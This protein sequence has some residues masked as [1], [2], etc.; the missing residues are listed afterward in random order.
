MSTKLLAGWETVIQESEAIK[1]A[2]PAPTHALP[3]D[4]PSAANCVHYIQDTQTANQVVSDLKSARIRAIGVDSEYGFNTPGISLRSKKKLWFDIRSQSPIVVSLAVWIG[5]ARDSSAGHIVQYVFDVRRKD[6][7]HALAEILRLR[8]PFVFHNIK[9]ELFTF[10]ALGIEPD[11][12]D[13]YD[14]Y[15]AAASLVLGVHH[16]RGQASQTPD[17]EAGEIE[18]KETADAKREH[19]LSLT[20][21]CRQYSHPHPFEK[22]KSRLQTEFLRLGPGDPLSEEQ[23]AYAAA[24]ATFTVKVFVAQQ[25]DVIRLAI[26][27]HLQTIELPFAIAN[28][29]IEWNG[30]HVALEAMEKLRVG[31]LKAAD[32]YGHRLMEAGMTN[33][34]SSKQF[35]NLMAKHDLLKHFTV[36]T[37]GGEPATKKSVLET[38]EHLHPTVAAYR[39]HQK[40]SRL[41]GEEWLSGKMVGVDGRIHSQ[42]RQLGAHSGRNSCKQPNLA[43]IGKNFRPIVSA[44]PGRAIFELDYSQIEVG[45]VAAEYNDEKLIAAYNSGDVYTFMANEF[46]AS[47]IH[48]ASAS[49]DDTAFRDFRK[50]LRDKMKT[51]VLAVLYNIQAPAIAQRFGITVREAEAQRENFL[52]LFPGVKRALDDSS[53]YGALRGYAVTVT[54]LKRHIPNSQYINQWVRNFLRNTPIQGS[55]SDVFK[56]AV[57]AVDRELLG[58]TACI[59]LSIH[60]ASLIECDLADLNVLPAKTQIIKQQVLKSFYPKLNAKV[61]VNCSKPHCWNKDGHADSL[62][63]FLADPA[64]TL[65]QFRNIEEETSHE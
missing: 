39:L 38:L 17:E 20:S 21:Q 29:R 27:H 15:L 30:A 46:Y 49:L 47:E 35:L 28:A 12:R 34:G 25:P 8:V 7:L 3:M 54:G 61:D 57:V 60:D 1:A 13:I 52:N 37:K 55:A 62:D 43:G 41:A 50:S 59:I 22:E 4:V 31:C 6:V 16:H 23:I 32:F 65:D 40:Y 51:F 44:P 53:T 56:A 2:L 9:A 11:F 36:K 24:D 26:N 5:D 63:K 58:S 42:H 64:F 48:V 10:W 19:Q 33:P 14:T 45:V 18:V